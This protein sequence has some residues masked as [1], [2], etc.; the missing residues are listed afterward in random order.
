[1]V[2]GSLCIDTELL[3]L[4]RK[5]MMGGDGSGHFWASVGARKG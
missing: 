3:P 5:M 1:M 2:L 4:L